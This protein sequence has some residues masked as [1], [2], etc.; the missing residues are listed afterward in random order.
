MKNINFNH[1]K[2]DKKKNQKTE[3]HRLPR[4]AL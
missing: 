3:K 2:N 1:K 4:E